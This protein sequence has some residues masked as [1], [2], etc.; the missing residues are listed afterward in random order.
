MTYSKRRRSHNSFAAVF[1]MPLSF[2]SNKIERIDAISSSV[3]P[4]V[5]VR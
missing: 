2:Y 3:T 1:L 5:S 4:T